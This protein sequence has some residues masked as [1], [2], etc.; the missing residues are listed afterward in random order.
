MSSV[1]IRKIEDFTMQ[2]ASPGLCFVHRNLKPKADPGVFRVGYIEQE[3]GWIDIGYP[4]IRE[5]A[6]LIGWADEEEVILL[7]HD[8]AHA[9]Y[10]LADLRKKVDDSTLDT[11]IKLSL[12]AQ[13]AD[14][15]ARRYKVQIGQLEEALSRT[16]PKKVSE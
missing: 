10:E 5:M 13:A 14:K 15:K 4:A 2:S 6:H 12:K 9:R 11:V 7:K 8:L 1:A 16:L 3:V